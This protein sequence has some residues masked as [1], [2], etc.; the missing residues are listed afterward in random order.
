[1][2]KTTAFKVR[3]TAAPMVIVLAWVLA[4]CSADAPPAASP[5]AIEVLTTIVV[6]EPVTIADELPGRVVAFRTAEI[7]A[8]VSG[9]I[10]HR[11]FDQGALVRTGQSLF[12]ISPAPFRAEAD[13]ARATLQ[14]ASAAYARA[15]TQVDRMR[16]L[17]VADAI[18]RQ[19]YDDAVAARDQALAEVAEARATLRRRQLDLGFSRVTAPI[20]GR[21][22]AANVTEGAL[23]ATGDANPLAIVQQIDRVYVDVRQPAERFAALRASSD[24]SA[25]VEIVAGSGQ[26]QSVKGRILFSGI[27]VDPGTGD[28]LVRVEVDNRSERLLPGMFVRARLPRA[29]TPAALTV[30]QQAVTRDA[31][32]A[33]Q[34]SIVDS[35]DRVHLRRVVLGG[36]D[37]GRYIILS[38]L[39]AGETVIVE[40]QDRVQPATPVKQRPW[41]S[42]VTH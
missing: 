22:G 6:P 42:R 16:P 24:A 19:S 40:G 36:V 29:A 10:Q 5:T 15:R 31:D 28:A 26:G 25:P 34:V 17:V 4:G 20:A 32:G 14:K 18:S 9:I 3:Y 35:A 33:A 39:S 7:R 41:R 1:M 12:Q 8:Q 27:T 2:V 37:H 11:L 30:P 38:G 21:I 23:V 13:T